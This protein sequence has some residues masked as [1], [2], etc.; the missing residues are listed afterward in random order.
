M[1]NLLNQLVIWSL[2]IV[3]TLYRQLLGPY[4]FIDVTSNYGNTETI[5]ITA[6]DGTVITIYCSE[7][8][9]RCIYSKWYVKNHI[10]TMYCISSTVSNNASEK[11]ILACKMKHSFPRLLH[12]WMSSMS[13]KKAVIEAY[14]DL[15]LDHLQ[16]QS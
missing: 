8:R 2:R 11:H 16:R 5:T 13:Q 10:V 14:I 4:I 3:S 9:Y 1:I 7:K 12:P 6:V 15:L